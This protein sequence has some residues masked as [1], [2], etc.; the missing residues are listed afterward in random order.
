[1]RCGGIAVATQQGRIGLSVVEKAHG[2][3]ARERVVGRETNLNGRVAAACGTCS[4]GNVA[5]D[6]SLRP[7][8]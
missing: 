8:T 7:V 2:E 3:Q 6:A 5:T 4:R 1:M